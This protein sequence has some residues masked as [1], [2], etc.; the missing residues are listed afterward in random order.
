MFQDLELLLDAVPNALSIEEY[1]AAIEDANCLG[2]RTQMTRKCSADY[3]I[4][5]YTLNPESILFRSLLYFWVRDTESRA[6]LALLCSSSRDPL[7]RSSLKVILNTPESTVLPRIV[8]EEFIEALEPGRFSKATLKSI[9]Q[10]LNSSWTKSG[11][12]TGRIKKIRTK[13]NATAASVTY[14]LYLGYLCGVRGPEL[15]E[16]DFV[17]MM[18]CNREKAIE[19][20]EI[21][22]QKGWLVFKRIGNVMELLFPNLITKEEVE[23][24]RG[25][26]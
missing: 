9:A 16:T 5:L 14:A 22:S 13:A 10:N 18:D 15:F 3:L 26:N 7:L 1:R 24:F 21:A 19:L 6:L 11:H 12:L 2:K 23:Y 8:M 20:A 25:Q 17:K 4:E